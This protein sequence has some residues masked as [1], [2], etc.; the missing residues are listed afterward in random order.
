MGVAAGRFEFL[1]FVELGYF[2]YLVRSLLAEFFQQ[3]KGQQ[4]NLQD[5]K[6]STGQTVGRGKIFPLVI[7]SLP[8]ASLPFRVSRRTPYLDK[9]YLTFIDFLCMMFAFVLYLIH[10]LFGH[11]DSTYRWI[12]TRVAHKCFP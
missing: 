2:S 3:R 8:E 9:P 6:H 1:N 12:L 10:F 4:R 7:A 11:S 5:M